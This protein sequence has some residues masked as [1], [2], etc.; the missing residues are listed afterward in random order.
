MISG[1]RYIANYISPKEEVDLITRID[2]QVWMT[3]LK[4]RVQ[5]Y[6]YVYDYKKR[7]VTEDMF[8]GQLPDFLE[9]IAIRTHEDGLIA[10]IP[11]QVIINEYYPGQGIAAHVD[12]EPC[13]G[14]T[15]LSLSLG[16]ACVMDF[17]ECEGTRQ[18]QILLEPRGLIIM[19]GESR[20]QWQHGIAARKSDLVNGQ[21]QKRTRRLSLT[22]RKVVLA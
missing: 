19:Q 18:E 5:H 22:L 1:L 4:R 16:S 3:G 13:F 12:C 20:Y 2:N 14:D 11:D 15:I 8:L 7:T 10:V 6:G 9:A 17:Y 21:R